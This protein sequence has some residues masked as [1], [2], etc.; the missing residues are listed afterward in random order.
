MGVSV[1]AINGLTH[2]ATYLVRPRTHKI[3]ARKSKNSSSSLAE[4]DAGVEK[5]EV[6]GQGE[7]RKENKYFDS[8]EVSFFRQQSIMD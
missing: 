3:W 4:K 8:K 6:K 1:P 7:L 5:G 2:L